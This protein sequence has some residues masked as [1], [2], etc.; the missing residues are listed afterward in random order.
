[1]SITGVSMGLLFG[2]ILIMT[3]ISLIMYNVRTNSK[4]KADWIVSIVG[5]VVGIGLT[6]FTYVTEIRIVLG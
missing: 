1:M 6:V 2:C 3:G 4:I 5:L